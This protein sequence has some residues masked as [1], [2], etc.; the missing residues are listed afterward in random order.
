MAEWKLFDGDEPHV[1]TFAFHEHRERAPHLEQSVHQGRLN[2]ARELVLVAAEWVRVARKFE[3][4]RRVTVVDLGCGDGGLL[5]LLGEDHQIVT[6]HGYDFQPSNV[7]G[8]A[9]RQVNATSLN[10]VEDWATVADA[11]VYVIT[12]CL[13]HLARPHEMVRRIYARGAH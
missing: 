2:L 10:V 1:S 11:D 5:Q 7:N 6:A 12:E 9:D 13:E 3:A 4:G 8:W